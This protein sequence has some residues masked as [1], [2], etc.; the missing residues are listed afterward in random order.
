MPGD[1]YRSGSDPT[2]AKL[3]ENE[4]SVKING[5]GK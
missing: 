4:L 1:C 2:A 5:T 3:I